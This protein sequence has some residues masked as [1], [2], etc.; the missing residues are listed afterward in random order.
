VSRLPLALATLATLA[1]LS[2]PAGAVSFARAD[3]NGDGGVTYAEA[4]RVFPRL[5]EVHFRKCDPNRD[6]VITRNEF[7]LLNNFYTIMYLQTG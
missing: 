1:T 5:S 3:P 7:P 4:R 6:G 2:G